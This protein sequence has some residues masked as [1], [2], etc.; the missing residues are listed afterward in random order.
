DLQ[1]FKEIV[2]GIDNSN[3]LIV[4]NCGKFILTIFEKRMENHDLPF[5]MQLK[6]HLA[7]QKIPCPKPI[8][9]KQNSLISKIR[10]K[11]AAIVTFLEG[12]TLKPNEKGNYENITEKH[13]FEVGRILALLHK[14][15]AGF[16]GKR[17]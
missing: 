5:F 6:L 17:E 2:E 10:N 4:T 1:S 9:S 15:V 13:C 12:T 8:L 14:A 7:E 3:F 16:G 11:P